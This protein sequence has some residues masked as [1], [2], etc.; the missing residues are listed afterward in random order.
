MGDTTFII[1]KE[2]V[3]IAKLFSQQISN[4]PLERKGGEKRW[5]S[6]R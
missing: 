3:L 4:L 1:R 2:L 6:T 5:I